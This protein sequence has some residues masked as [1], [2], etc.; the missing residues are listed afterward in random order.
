VDQILVED[1]PQDYDEEIFIHGEKF[2]KEELMQKLQV[3]C[4]DLSSDDNRR[5]CIALCEPA[6][7]CREKGEEKCLGDPFCNLFASC[8]A[9]IDNSSNNA[10]SGKVFFVD[11]HKYTEAEL[12]KVIRDMCLLKDLSIQENHDACADLCK[13]GKCCF[14][15]GDK[16][17]KGDSFCSA[18]GDCKELLL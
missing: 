1:H 10:D 14:R 6:E 15:S 4:S 7:C 5:T 3:T 16:S 18:F 8:S 2:S 17:C 12:E 9:L 13:L 11:G